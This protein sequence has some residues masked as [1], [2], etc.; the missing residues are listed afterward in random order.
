M[1][2]IYKSEFLLLEFD[3]SR[4]ILE[5]SWLE[6]NDKMTEE[7][8]KKE[9]ETVAALIKKHKPL[10]I[11]TNDRNRTYIYTVELQN[12]VA[13]I[14]SNAC[15]EAGIKKFAVMLPEE[16]VAQI[17]TEQTA[18]EVK[19]LPYELQLFTEEQEAIEWLKM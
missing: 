7:Q 16:I 5:S 17:S 11:L 15:I 18:D 8:M 10:F 19:N 3:Q 6:K 13:Q 9:I 14:L 12:W 1:G 2:T 4:K